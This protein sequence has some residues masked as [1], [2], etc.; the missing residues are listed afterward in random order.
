MQ[1]IFIRKGWVS[2]LKS[3]L[4]G[5][6]KSWTVWFN[7]LMT[8]FIFYQPEIEAKLQAALTPEDYANVAL[9]ILIVNIVLRIK[10]NTGLQNK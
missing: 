4:K 6:A 2:E 9:G 1:F 5:A 7:G 8:A 3:W 10:T